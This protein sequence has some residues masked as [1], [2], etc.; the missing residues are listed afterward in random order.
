MLFGKSSFWH[1]FFR[2]ED[3]LSP[4]SSSTERERENLEETQLKMDDDFVAE[5]TLCQLPSCH[6]FQIPRLANASGHR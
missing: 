5:R 1:F 4:H 2:A 6:V 3:I